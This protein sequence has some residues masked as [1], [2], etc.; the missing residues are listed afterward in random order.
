[1]PPPDKRD[2]FPVMSK[3]ELQALRAWIDEGVTWPSEVSV[4][5]PAN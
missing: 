2:K 4:K 5:P 3:E 1:M